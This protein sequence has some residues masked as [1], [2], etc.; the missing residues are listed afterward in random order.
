VSALQS[1]QVRQA[2]A[3]RRIAPSRLLPAIRRQ[4]SLPAIDGQ[5]SSADP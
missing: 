1:P 2:W 4:E 5:T 3:P